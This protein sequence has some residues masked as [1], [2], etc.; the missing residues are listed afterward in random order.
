M[1][2]KKLL[3]S[4]C[5]LF[6]IGSIFLLVVSEKTEVILVSVMNLLMFGVGG[7]CVYVL[8]KRG[9][10]DIEE[11]K[12]IIITDKRGKM[13]ALTLACLCFVIVCYLVLPFNHLFDGNRR[14][15][16]SLGYIVGIA[17]ILF[18]G[19]GFISSI[20][21][22]IKPKLTMQISDEGLVISKGLKNQIFIAWRNIEEVGI[23]ETFLLIYLKN[24]NLY[25]VNRVLNFLNKRLTGTNINIPINS[26]NYNIEQVENIIRNKLAL[27]KKTVTV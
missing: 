3:Y 15:T 8:E 11:E 12:T 2:N 16:P 25:P 22:L 23:N 27:H 24:P 14:Y 20:I 19:F 4:I 9:N 10:K 13:I 5:I 21:R 18:F 6:T 1:K 7:V 26:I 17:G